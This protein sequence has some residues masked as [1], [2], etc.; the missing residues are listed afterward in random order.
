MLGQTRSSMTAITITSRK[1]NQDTSGAK[2]LTKKG[3]VIITDRGR[4]A[5]V[6]MTIE[7]YQ[8]LLGRRMSLAEAVAQPDAA[9]TFDPPRLTGPL[10]KRID[11]D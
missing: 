4:P 6:L 1:F 11:F 3:P 2:K 5:H 9:F 7:E 10:F 8:R